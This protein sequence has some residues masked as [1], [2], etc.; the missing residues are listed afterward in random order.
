M[1]VEK[2]KREIRGERKTRIV[3]ESNMKSS[4]EAKNW[5]Q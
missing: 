5:E 2:S 4:K 1:A 3:L